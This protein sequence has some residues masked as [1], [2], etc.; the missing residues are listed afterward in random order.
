[1]S[2]LYLRYMS[3]LQRESKSIPRQFKKVNY[4]ELIN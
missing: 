1:M 4:L 3:E 2:V